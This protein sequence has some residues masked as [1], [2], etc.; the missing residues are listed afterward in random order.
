MLFVGAD[1]CLMEWI[2]KLDIY[3]STAFFKELYQLGLR[4]IGQNEKMSLSP[5]LTVS[6]KPSENTT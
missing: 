4:G 5:Q 1:F 2:L 3:K 6:R